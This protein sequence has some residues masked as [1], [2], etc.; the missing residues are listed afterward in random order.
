MRHITPGHMVAFNDELQKSA[1][2]MPAIRSGVNALRGA[3]RFFHND[4]G[5]RALA[6]ANR[7]L[8]GK[9]GRQ[10]ATSG[11]AGAV[12]GAALADPDE[13][14]R[15][16]GALQGALLGAGL[17]TGTVLA[18]SKGR[19]AMA[20]GL[21]NFY[22]RQ[23]YALTGK[24]LGKTDAE[25][26]RKAQDI[27]L[28]SKA[29]PAKFSADAK[30]QKALMSA[31][32][33]A[34]MEED[35]LLKGYMSAPGTVHGLLT[36][37]LDVMK[38]GWK[39]GGALGKTFAGL[40]AYD[41]VRGFAKKPEEGGPGR[42]EAGLRGAGSAVGWLVAPHTLAGAHLVGMGGG[43]VG[44]KAGKVGD[45]AVRAV[46]S[47]GARAPMRAPATPQYQ[48]ANRV[49]SQPQGRPVPQGGYQ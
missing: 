22:Q 38:S 45:A 30:G 7:E 12:A 48:A 13:K 29:T 39:R 20:R 24:G 14:S 11:G 42:L 34:R 3:R 16:T 49:P 31:Q 28:I 15:F 32:A 33:R 25:K 35:A 1:A 10:V 43:Y 4:P 41:T 36:N 47:R 8:S 6:L 44:G 27:G 21:G 5:G 37:P 17:G 40:G 18:R 19:E 23:R 9:Y 46:R 2:I 26:V